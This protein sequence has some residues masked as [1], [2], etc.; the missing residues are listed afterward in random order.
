MRST[1]AQTLDAWHYG[2]HYEKLPTLS[3]TWIQEGTENIDRTLAVQSENSHQFICD[4]FFD[5]TWT[6]PMPIYSIPGLN[7]I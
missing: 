4:F 5:Q 7:T 1:Y 6:R 3:S 2:D